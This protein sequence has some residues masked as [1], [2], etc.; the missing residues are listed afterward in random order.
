MVGG[1]AEVSLKP[2]ANMQER[3]ILRLHWVRFPPKSTPMRTREL[4]EDVPQD[5]GSPWSKIVLS[6]NCHHRGG[7]LP[8]LSLEISFP[9]C[10]CDF[11]AL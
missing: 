3:P 2:Y 10:Q 5:R 7:V 4:D 6:T 1:G 11:L 8:Y 9:R